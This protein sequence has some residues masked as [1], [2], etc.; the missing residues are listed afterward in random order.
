MIVLCFI[1]FGGSGLKR[2]L[3]EGEGEGEGSHLK[4]HMKQCSH[5]FIYITLSRCGWGAATSTNFLRK[6]RL[7]GNLFNFFLSRIILLYE[8]K[9]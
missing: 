9:C 5:A 8:R 6:Y 4:K 3:P 2:K 7:I 1:K